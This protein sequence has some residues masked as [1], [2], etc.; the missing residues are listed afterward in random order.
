MVAKTRGRA[1]REDSLSR[2]RIVA[3]AVEMLDSV[4]ESR[5]T[6][7]GL[8]AELRTGLGALYWHVD[9]KGDVLA[10]ATEAVLA[11]ALAGDTGE[12]S[13]EDA[14][15]AIALGV[16]DAF[17]THPWIG[18]QLTRLESQATTVRI[19]ERLG[20]QVQAL[21]VAEETQF[22]AA[23]TLVNYILGVA[24]QNAALAASV[25]PGTDRDTV[26][27][28]VSSEW[29]GLDAEEFAFTRGIASRLPGHDDR[30]QFLAG[31]GFILAGIRPAP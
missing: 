17:D 23:S 3:A 28:N 27:A 21:G 25:E 6:V 24:G 1:R 29:A 2:E 5:L 26:L 9:N 7:R 19:F 15:R 12:Q 14:I 18:A 8:A 11:D 30:D 31:V 13:P 22:D 20:R 16:F 4:G 10:A